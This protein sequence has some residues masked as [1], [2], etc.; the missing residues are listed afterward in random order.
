MYA[1][2]GCATSLIDCGFN[3]NRAHDHDSRSLRHGLDDAFAS[4][5]NGVAGGA[6]TQHADDD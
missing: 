6:V 1:K 5:Q 2:F 4:E 3:R